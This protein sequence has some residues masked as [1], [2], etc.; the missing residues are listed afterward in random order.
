[1]NKRSPPVENIFRV[2]YG[3]PKTR[4]QTGRTQWDGIDDKLTGTDRSS[5]MIKC[6]A[7][8]ELGMCAQ[9]FSK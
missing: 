5:V 6:E 4:P 7:E 8:C 3:P 9:E 2:V 1:M